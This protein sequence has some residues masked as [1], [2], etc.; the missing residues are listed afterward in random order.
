VPPEDAKEKRPRPTKSRK[1][2]AE[3]ALSGIR[4]AK[5]G[6]R[7]ITDPADRVRILLAEAN[8]LALL[9]VADALSPLPA[10]GEKSQGAAPA[11]EG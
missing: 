11:A 7:E 1:S 10:A 3:R 6:Q 2:H 5:R 4:V 8:I 9:D